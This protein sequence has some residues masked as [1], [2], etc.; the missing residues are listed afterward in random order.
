LPPLLRITAG[1]LVDRR[2]PSTDAPGAG[3]PNA[4]G[5]VLQ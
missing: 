1:E 5:S 3:D 4:P 2:P